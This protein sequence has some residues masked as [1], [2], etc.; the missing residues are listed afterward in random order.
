MKAT[1]ALAVGYIDPALE[2]QTVLFICPYGQTLNGCNS[3]TCM[4]NGEWEPDPGEIECFGGM[5]TTDV[6][7][8]GMSALKICYVLVF[9]KHDTVYFIPAATVTS[10]ILCSDPLY[11]LHILNDSMKESTKESMYCSGFL[12]A[13][14]NTT[15][16]LL[17]PFSKHGEWGMGIGN[18]TTPN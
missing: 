5:G 9:H 6:T 8:S 15:L 14:T 2:G 12:I 4:G 7:T 3:S 18:I 11:V 1:N 17:S 13:R 16:L 10:I